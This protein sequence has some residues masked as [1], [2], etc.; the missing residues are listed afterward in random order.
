MGKARRRPR[1]AFSSISH[2]VGAALFLVG[3]VVLMVLARGRPDFVW[4]FLVYGGCA[5]LLY[6]ASGIYH[7]SHHRAEE[8]Q[9]FDYSAIYLMIAGTYTPVCVVA[10]AKPLGWW[11]LAA[12]WGMAATGLVHSFVF[13]GRPHWIRVVLYLLMGWLAVGVMGALRAGMPAP[14][15][16]WLLA[17]GLLYT[18]GTVIYATERPRLWPGRF[19]AHDLWHLFVLAASACHYA[20][21]VFLAR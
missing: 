18:F 5:I 6:L 21:M 1:E 4:S 16:W 9:K 8:L 17:G 7:A 11:V 3:L 14:G 10:L 19:G 12:E 20:T 2:L 13:A 15:V